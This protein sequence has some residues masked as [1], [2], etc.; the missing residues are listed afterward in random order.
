MYIVHVNRIDYPEESVRKNTLS[1]ALDY[2][3]QEAPRDSFV[4]IEDTERGVQRD[5]HVDSKGAVRRCSSV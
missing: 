5:W 4:T 1:S 2:L 3:K